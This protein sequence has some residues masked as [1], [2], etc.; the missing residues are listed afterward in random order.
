MSALVDGFQYF[1]HFHRLVKLVIL[2]KLHSI[3]GE[4]EV[5]RM[6]ESGDFVKIGPR[7]PARCRD[8][9]RLVYLWRNLVFSPIH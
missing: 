5:S 7:Q 1:R 9:G 2:L 8:L 6:R 3:F 4:S